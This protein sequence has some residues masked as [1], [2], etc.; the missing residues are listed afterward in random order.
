[1][2]LPACFADAVATSTRIFTQLA[3]THD[4]FVRQETA[5]R[6]NANGSCRVFAIGDK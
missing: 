4:E 6:L 3:R 1:M 2:E 5:T